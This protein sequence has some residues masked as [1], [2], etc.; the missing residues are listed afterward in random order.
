MQYFLL[1][2]LIAAHLVTDFLIQ[3]DSGVEERRRNRW[4]SKWLYVHAGLAGGAAYLF[5]GLWHN[6]WLPAVIGITHLLIDGIKAKVRDTAK[7]F[8]IDQFCHVAVVIVCW[9]FLINRLALW[10]SIVQHIGDP[11]LWI[12]V[13]SYILI[14]WPAGIAIGKVT[15]RWKKSPPDRGA[16]A[17]SDRAGL[18]IGRLER[19]LIFTFI[20]LG[21]FEAIGFL[22][23]AKSIFRFS[24][25]HHQAEYIIIGSLLSFSVAVVLGV[26]VICVS[27]LQM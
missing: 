22:I 11:K 27:S 25:V 2:R 4:S 19:F 8:L 16:N 23:A 1:V 17:Q 12:I 10:A 13:F 15:A 26:L 21:H 14:V 9:A 5:S 20:L 18:L 7:T 6:F 3:P 24:E